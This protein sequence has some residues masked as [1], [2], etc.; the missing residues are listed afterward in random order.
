[1]QRDFDLNLGGNTSQEGGE[2]A[3]LLYQVYSW[4][5]SPFVQTSVPNYNEI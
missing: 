2:V 3:H 1:M 4:L 5:F